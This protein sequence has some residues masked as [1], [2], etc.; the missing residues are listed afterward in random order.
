[1]FIFSDLCTKNSGRLQKG[2]MMA[3]TWGLDGG[4]SEVKTSHCLSFYIV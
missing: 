4:G 3:Q 1:M 2:L